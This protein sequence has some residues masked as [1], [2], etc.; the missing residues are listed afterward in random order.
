[1]PVH[2]ARSAAVSPRESRS[3]LSNIPTYDQR[4]ELSTTFPASGGEF[5]AT[6]HL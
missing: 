1:M 5:D 3:T 4:M 2:A 6:E